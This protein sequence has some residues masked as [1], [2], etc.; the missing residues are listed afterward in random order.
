MKY[1][2][3]IYSIFSITFANL[4]AL[5]SDSSVTN[6]NKYYFSVAGGL[7]EV[8][9]KTKLPI[10]PGADD[11]GTFSDGEDWGYY[12]GLRIGYELLEG[13][14][15]A[16][17]GLIYENRPIALQKT[18]SSY[19][20]FSP[21][22][23]KYEPFIRLHEY[24]GSLQYVDFEAA[25]K[26]MP[27]QKYPFHLKLAF[28]IGNPLGGTDFTNYE[29]IV[30]PDGV[31]FP[32][33]TLKRLVDGGRLESAGTNFAS[34]VGLSYN[35]YL[36][37]NLVISP[38]VQYRIGLNSVLSDA[39]WNT[40]IL[41]LGIAVSYPFG[42]D[43][44]KKEI[45][46]PEIVPP[47]VI[48]TPVVMVD[49]KKTPPI[50][51][52]NLYVSPFSLEQTTVTQ[53]YP[54][55]PY[56]FFD[57]LSSEI[58]SVYLNNQNNS[59]FDESS[60]PKDNLAIYYRILDLIGNRLSKL[61]K[62]NLTINGVS[63]GSEL[64]NSAARIRLGQSRAQSIKNYLVNFWKIHPNRIFV[65]SQELPNV[66]TTMQYKEGFAENRR[67]ELSSDNADIF[68][69]VSHTDFLEFAT[70]DSKISIVPN[71][72][73][74]SEIKHWTL[75]LSANDKI[76]YNTRGDAP[77]STIEID[78]SQSLIENLASFTAQNVSIKAIFQTID[79][80]NNVESKEIILPIE[81][82]TQNYELGRLNL[83]VFDFDRS[84]LSKFNQDLIAKFVQSSI[85]KESLIN[86][87][88][89]TDRLGDDAY[90]FKLSSARADNVRAFI[91]NKFNLANITQVKG[92]GS[93]ELKYN[94]DLPEGRFYCRTVLIEVKTPLIQRR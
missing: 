84:D 65:K 48:D 77:I 28:G 12:A 27:L 11:C 71:I 63:D 32:N 93:S 25:L 6:E 51:I 91:L 75:H 61:E 58:S 21:I 43:T 3:L 9:N 29:Q 70:S 68:E 18:S 66:P 55:L 39:E 56:I 76:L 73:L 36:K 44:P 69:P 34:I 16:E 4:N 24:N 53:T 2:L 79:Y 94:N 42:K 20:V 40:D 17:L 62:A 47:T 82:K 88:G 72:N 1:I 14:V 26:F 89:S 35:F 92:I 30:S 8:F 23:N 57:S 31:L 64:D 78:L 7:S 80:E 59:S 60:L 46:L 86:I 22:T 49:V 81:L 90:N 50:R 87:T 54:I 13:L 52:K 10:I 85:K 67:V 83:I 15:T 41:R 33:N 45:K 5:D 37:N 74:M 38:E 19:Q